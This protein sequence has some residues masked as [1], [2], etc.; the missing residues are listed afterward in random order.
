MA[1]SRVPSIRTIWLP[2]FLTGLIALLG[3]EADKSSRPDFD[4]SSSL[5]IRTVEVGA[6]SLAAGDSTTVR[7]QVV[8]GSDATPVPGREVVFG[9]LFGKRS[10]QFRPG[11]V[12]TGA[13]GWAQTVFRS[14]PAA[15]GSVAIKATVNEVSQYAPPIT[16]VPVGEDGLR[17]YLSSPSGATAVAGDGNATLTLR[18]TALYGVESQ[19]V[20]GLPVRIVA[21]ER[22][23]DSDLDGVFSDG[24]LFT[25]GGDANANGRWDAIGSV[26]EQVLTDASGSA[27]F[28]LRSA[29]WTGTTYVR[30]T[31]DQVGA[32]LPIQFHPNSLQITLGTQVRELMADGV[33]TTL[34]SAVVNDWNGTPVQGIIVRFVAGES[35]EDVGGDGEYNPGDPFT[36]S[37]QNGRWDPKGTI[38]SYDTTAEDGSAS[39]TYRAGVE[40][41]EVWIRA[42]VTG[43]SDQRSLTLVRV[44]RA[45]SLNLVLDPDAVDADGRSP[46]EGTVIVRDINGTPLAG[47]Q[48]RIVAGE[49]FDDL[50]SDGLYT[51]G[52]DAFD[53][54]DDLDGDG[55][56]TAIGDV[57]PA[58]VVTGGGGEGVFEYIAGLVPG[59]VEIRATADAVAS[60][61]QLRLRPLP[62]PVSMTVTREREE[63]TVRG[64][65]GADNVILTAV[66]FDALG[67][68]VP[69]G[70]PVEFTILS[71]PGGGEELGD[72]REGI[73]LTRTDETGRA[74]AL[75]V[76]GTRVGIVEVMATSGTVMRTIQVGVAAGSAATVQ[77]NAA[78]TILDFWSQTKVTAYATDLHGNPVRNG[79]IVSW[80][81][82]EG[83]VVGEDGLATSQT[84]N[85]RAMADYFSLGPSLG[86]DYIA[87]VTARV[88][89]STIQGS[90]EIQLNVTPPPP[91]AEIEITSNRQR[92]NVRRTGPAETA[93]IIVRA[94]EVEGQAVGAGYPVEFWIESGP[95][96]G[97]NLNGQGWGHVVSETNQDGIATV[98]LE[99]GTLPGPVRIKAQGGTAN[100]VAVEIQIIAGPPVELLCSATPQQVESEETA[101]IRAYL[102]DLYHNP[103]EDGALVSFQVDEG[104]V[105][106][107][108]GPG[109]SR[110][111]GGVAVATYY[112]LTPQQGGDG[113]AEIT[114]TAEGGQLVCI[115]HVRIPV[116]P[117]GLSELSL[118]AAD[119]ELSVR[120]AGGAEETALSVVARSPGGGVVGPGYAIRVEILSGPDG[121]ESLD[122]IVGGPI[123][124]TTDS[125]GEVETTLGSGTVSGTVRVRA[126]YGSVMS[127]TLTIPIRPGPPDLLE[128]WPGTAAVAEDDTTSIFVVV[129]DLHRNPVADSSVV[130]FEVDEGRVTGDAYPGASIG[131]TVGGYTRGLYHCF[132]DL[133]GGD[134]WAVIRCSTIDGTSCDTRISIPSTESEVASIM[135]E[136]LYSEVGVA[137]TGARDQTPLI[138]TLRNGQGGRLGSG[139]PVSFRIVSGPGGGELIDGRTE[140]VD[141][142]TRVDGTAVVTLTGGTRSGLVTVDAASGGRSSNQC[143]V[144]IG[145]GPPAQIECSA[146]DSAACGAL[147]SDGSVRAHVTDVYHNP[148]RDGTV[149]WFS[150][151]RG[152]I[153]GLADLASSVTDNGVAVAIYRAPL[154]SE[155]ENWTTATLTFRVGSL[156]CTQVVAKSAGP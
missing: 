101:E 26:P 11:S 31:A 84:Q 150:A 14:D 45:A 138:A 9:E 33:S 71:G 32:E 144:V 113:V 7:A 135:L 47:K 8:E 114:C 29:A 42:S 152:L 22:F 24:D 116:L 81:V 107:L 17:L 130:N 123:L 49:H 142:V 28:T 153:T 131:Y 58:V 151:D 89:N 87:A 97:E 105:V 112:S 75:L 15:A 91:I 133:V 21:G 38:D 90:L 73:Y 95:Q 19:P 140:S 59:E 80:S 146:P 44:P 85:G 100:F 62:P 65:G 20:Q 125:R 108:D 119:D 93:E 66:C 94:F 104:M 5:R 122:G 23:V 12:L 67:N 129:R 132:A 25:P 69:A 52:V 4:G 37:N 92:I 103:V 43:G 154:D 128:C 109:S 117:T 34:V 110:T 88:Q 127:N 120:S 40:S 10:G 64:G 68:Q 136:A 106:G 3:C 156:V 98:R 51:P 48:V 78:D 74:R 70:V 126:R 149:V 56:W 82:D 134:G 148:V 60:M 96:G 50:D 18:V 16:I 35:F 147:L 30:A 86:T 41:G 2:A 72:A 61:G 143:I 39:A 46:V 121:G 63:I 76:A 1:S 53:P 27:E 111:V 99:A 83:M 139:V 155:C 118:M 36:D 13:D 145:A 102:Y 57:A 115:S 55:L 54:A 124:L 79:T 77:V 137:G 6:T 141:A